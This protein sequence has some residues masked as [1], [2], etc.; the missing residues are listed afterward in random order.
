MG[1]LRKPQ[2]SK[3]RRSFFPRPS[4]VRSMT[5][6]GTFVLF[7]GFVVITGIPPALGASSLYLPLILKPPMCDP[8]MTLTSG[9]N[10]IL[11]GTPGDD[12]ICEYGFGGNII[13]YAEGAAG[14]DTIYQDC[15]VADTC[16]QTAIAGDGNDTVYQYGGK[17]DTTQ[18]VS[19]DGAGEKD[20]RSVRWPGEKQYDCRRRNWNKQNHHVR[21]SK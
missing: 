19:G 13:Q 3:E 15:R 1:E 6:G 20:Y 11:F 10:Q 7:L 12:H 8:A 4:F 14:N 17:G 2:F 18:Y 16:D 9:D 5:L 21:R